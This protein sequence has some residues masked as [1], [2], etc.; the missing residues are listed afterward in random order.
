MVSNFTLRQNARTQ[1]GGNIFK[2]KWMMML[3]VCGILPFA[4]SLLAMTVLAFIAVIVI[5][6]PFSYG[7]ARAQVLCVENRKWDIMHVF[8]GFSEDF[9]G[10][11]LL[12]F[13]RALLTMLWSFLFVV[14]GIIKSYS[15]AMAFYIRQE[16]DGKN[17]EAIDC[18]TESR[19][20]MDG[21]KWQLFCLD[22]SF[23]GWYLVG[24]LC[25][26]L[27]TLFVV[28]YHEMARA[29]F[30][31]ALKAENVVTPPPVEEEPIPQTEEQEEN[32]V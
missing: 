5:S 32:N 16:A 4:Q 13:L 1:L 9:G 10:S 19:R 11:V 17:K 31:E 25:L 12:G 7:A 23:I 22:L 15:Y 2:N 29:N 20:L 8:C 24:A 21:H 3:V 18:I 6:G 27:G 26:G 30:Y 28:P 14:P